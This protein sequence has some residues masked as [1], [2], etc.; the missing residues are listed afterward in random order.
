[1]LP[2]WRQIIQELPVL[3]VAPHDSLPC[4]LT[5]WR[6]LPVKFPS[7]AFRFVSL[8]RAKV[9]SGH[10]LDS[11]LHLAL[12]AK[13]VPRAPQE[14]CRFVLDLFPFLA[15]LE[16]V[17]RIMMGYHAVEAKAHCRR[18][19]ARLVGVPLWTVGIFL[20]DFNRVSNML[21]GELEIFLHIIEYFGIF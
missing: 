15:A 16:P 17:Q 19:F 9:G 1:M 3:Q 18:E 10:M 7:L 11:C 14:W 6:D 12:S 20:Q 5:I 8:F 2:I 13:E 21:H 4:A